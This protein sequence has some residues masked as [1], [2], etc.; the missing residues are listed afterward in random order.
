MGYP[1]RLSEMTDAH[2]IE[3]Q[4]RNW[5][6]IATIMMTIIQVL[7]IASWFMR[8]DRSGWPS[9]SSVFITLLLIYFLWQKHGWARVVIVAIH[10]LGFFA[11]AFILVVGWSNMETNIRYITVI[12][13]LLCANVAL[14]VGANRSLAAYLERPS[15][16]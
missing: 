2:D 6:V 11:G 8:P 13:V 15:P 7:K 4:G 5:L 14:V 1:G 3:R 10:V 12:N 16:E 9:L